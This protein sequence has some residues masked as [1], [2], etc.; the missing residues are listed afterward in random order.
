MNIQVCE[1][2]EIK[3]NYRARVKLLNLDDI[4]TDFLPIL[5]PVAIGNK[6]YNLPKV[7]SLVLAVFSKNANEGFIIGSI[8][9]NKD[10]VPVKNK[11]VF[12]QEFEDGGFIKY[13][14]STGNLD[15]KT[16]KNINLNANTKIKITGDLEVTGSIS[17]SANLDVKGNISSI[18]K[19]ETNTDVICGAT[20]LKTHIHTGNLGAP[21]SPPTV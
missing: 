18:G 15:I 13:D 7:G 4:E 5:A 20:T 21:T 11:D 2:V 3:E 9:N 19:I 17:T 10:S 16:S 8:Y 6:T 1:I 12:M 14:N